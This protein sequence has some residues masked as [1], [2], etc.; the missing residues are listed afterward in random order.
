MPICQRALSLRPQGFTPNVRDG[1]DVG[2]FGHNLTICLAASL[3]IWNSYLKPAAFWRWILWAFLALSIFSCKFKAISLVNASAKAFPSCKGPGKPE[4]D[5]ICP[6]K[7]FLSLCLISFCKSNNKEKMVVLFSRILAVSVWGNNPTTYQESVKRLKVRSLKCWKA[8]ITALISALWADVSSVIWT[9]DFPL[10][11]VTALP[12]E[13]PSVKTK[14]APFKGWIENFFRK[15]TECV[16][17][18]C[19][20]RLWNKRTNETKF[21]PWNLSG[22]LANHHYFVKEIAVDSYWMESLY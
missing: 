1:L 14:I 17:K 10:I 2:Q 12:L 18:K 22:K 19:K 6:T 8:Q 9:W 20:S 3:G 7:Y 13:E 11:I 15:I 16:F 5:L 4:W 21:D